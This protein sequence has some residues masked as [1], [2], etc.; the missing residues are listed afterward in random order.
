M[1]LLF[2]NPPSPYLEND[3]A[4]PPMGLLYLAASAIEEGHSCKICDLSG[5]GKLSEFINDTN[6]DIAFVTCVTPNVNQVREI[7]FSLF[8]SR[9][10]NK[11]VVGGPHVTFMPIDSLRE[12]GVSIV[13]GEGDLIIK[14]II[15][16]YSQT[17]K[18]DQIYYGGNVQISDIPPPARHLINLKKYCGGLT[19]TIYTSRGC[20]YH[21]KFCSKITNNTYRKFPIDRVISE[22]EYCQT[23]GINSFIFGDDNIIINA[24][25]VKELLTRVADLDITFRLNQDAR[26]ID[27][28]IFE[29]AANSGC[30]DISFGIESGNQSMLDH[31]NKMTTVEL[32]KEAISTAKGCGISTK[33]Y[34]LVNF[35]GETLETISDTIKFAECAL[36]DKW[37]LSNFSPLPGCDVFNRPWDYG[38]NWISTD[39]SNYYLVG[40]GGGFKPSFTTNHLTGLTQLKQ[41]NL[42]FKSLK[43]V[44]G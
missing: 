37:L 34:F 30:T 27:K 20:P 24:D 39:W 18:I 25:H 10:C 33:A 5:G 14:K 13:V 29:L 32:N 41:H 6:Y 4:Y 17:G 23:Q 15:S 21:C 44:L 31:M 12:F 28:S 43:E 1:K 3:A 19:T 35:P 7:I 8:A 40:K 36:P 2:V 38:V 11:I 16:D 9:A 26:H 42:L 22:I